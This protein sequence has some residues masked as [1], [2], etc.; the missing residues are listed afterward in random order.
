MNVTIDIGPWYSFVEVFGNSINKNFTNT[1]FSYY[2]MYK[3]LGNTFI[4]YW[5]KLVVICLK[6]SK[7]LLRVVTFW[8]LF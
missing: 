1:V 8:I 3:P 4:N 7:Y 2:L 5:Y 6:L